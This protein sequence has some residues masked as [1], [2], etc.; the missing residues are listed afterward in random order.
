MILKYHGIHYAAKEGDEKAVD[1]A[2]KEGENVTERDQY[3]DTP[4]HLAIWA[5][6]EPCIRLLILSGASSKDLDARGISA[7][8]RAKQWGQS[9]LFD[10]VKS[11]EEEYI[12]FQK[13]LRKHAL[14]ENWKE[15]HEVLKYPGLVNTYLSDGHT[16]LQEAAKLDAVT[17]ITTLIQIGA[18]I[19]I[20][21]KCGRTEIHFAAESGSLRA[22][23]E[24][25]NHGADVKL[26][27]K[28]GRTPLHLAA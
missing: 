8:E 15:F 7:S 22:L 5:I 19:G 24:F 13:S 25:I 4:L 14:D 1:N 3:G 11:V 28:D 27:D 10:F 6:S 18:K 23:S 2:L 17:V 26:Q 12:E 21:S 20:K 9:K 16:L